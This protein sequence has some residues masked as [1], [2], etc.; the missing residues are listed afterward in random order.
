LHPYESEFSQFQHDQK[1][2]LL[3]R[4]SKRERYPYIIDHNNLF[5]SAYRIDG[6]FSFAGLQTLIRKYELQV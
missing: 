3:L 5:S 1:A 6:I 4:V 2:V